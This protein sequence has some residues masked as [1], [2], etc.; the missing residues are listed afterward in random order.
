MD[1][2]FQKRSRECRPEN[3]REICGGVRIGEM[4]GKMNPNQSMEFKAKKCPVC[5]SSDIQLYMKGIYD[6][7]DT[8]VLECSIC[9]LQFLEPL[10]TEKEEAD[11][12]DGYYRKQES[13]HFKKM[14]LSDLQDRALL[15]YEQYRSVYLDQIRG[16]ETILEIGS[17][18]GGF[19]K[20]VHKYFPEIKITSIERCEENIAFLRKTFGAKITLCAEPNEIRGQKFDRIFAFGVF[21][22]IR[23][24][25]EFLKETKAYLTDKGMMA[26][27]VPNKK[28]ALIYAY[29]IDEFKKFNYMKQHYY[30]FTEKALEFLALETNFS[31]RSFNYMQVWSLDNHLSWLRFRKPRDF[32]DFGN[33]ISQK[34]RD[35]YNQDLIEKKMTDLMMVVLSPVVL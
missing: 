27:N 1:R 20:F 24:S 13:R 12:Y 5:A 26:L 35:S 4:A 9:G 15:H 6:S 30:T 16:A 7:Q 25:R 18:T 19:L 8:D 29:Q 31:I 23:D 28:N 34:T 3:R 10:M 14:A 17:G 11:Y 22:H 2:V 33:L 21:E 32:S